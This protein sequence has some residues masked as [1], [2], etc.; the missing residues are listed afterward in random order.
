MR[1]IN[2]ASLLIGVA[3]SMLP[4]SPAIA[5]DRV[6]IGKL[7]YKQSCAACHGLDGKGKGSFSE[8]LQLT[9]PDLTTLSKNNGGVFPMSK[10]YEVIDG[11]QELKAHGTREMPIWGRHFAVSAAPMHDDF[12]YNPEAAARARILAVAEYIY[13][14]QAK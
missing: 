9:M 1:T 13:R 7:E 5:R 12:A 8:A 11:T 10:V 14:L 2:S 3:I 6:D 4:C